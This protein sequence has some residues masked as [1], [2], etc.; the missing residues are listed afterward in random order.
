MNLFCRDYWSFF[1]RLSEIRCT[2]FD[3]GVGVEVLE[4]SF[5]AEQAAL[6][7][8]DETA[9]AVVGRAVVLQPG[10][11]ERQDPSEELQECHQER[12]QRHR[13]QMVAK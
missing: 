9:A 13:S 11:D 1:Q 8:F 6:A 3:V 4:E 2:Y 5:E 10:L 12:S 7:R